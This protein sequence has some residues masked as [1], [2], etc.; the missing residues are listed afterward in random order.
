MISGAGSIMAAILDASTQP[1]YGARVAAVISD[2]A[3]ASGLAIAAAAGIPTAV[4]CVDDFPDR[5]MWDAAIK[6]TLDAFSPDLVVLAGFMRILGQPVL[7]AYEGKI[8]NTHPALLPAYPGA[9]GVRDALAGGAKITG[10]T[11]M[12]ID[13]GVDTGPILAQAAV[14]VRDNDNEGSLHERI[15]VAERRLVVDTVGSMARYGWTVDGRV[16]RIGTAEKGE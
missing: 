8:I 9:H 6:R 12:I 15:K 13:A 10:C 1:A 7:E 14:E 11:V 3:S 16:A 5:G 4:V 2:R